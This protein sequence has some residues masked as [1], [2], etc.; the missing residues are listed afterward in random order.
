MKRFPSPI[1]WTAVFLL[2]ITSCQ[3]K[4]TVDTKRVQTYDQ[5]EKLHITQIEPAGWIKE[6]L[7][8][9][10]RGLTGNIEVA[11]Y[12]FNTCLWACEKMEGSTKAWWP[13]E[14]TAYYLD[15]VHRLG[16][17][18]HD[19]ELIG[20]VRE[21]THY[22]LN[23]IDSTGRFGTRLSDRWWRWP[24]A[25]FNRLL[26][27]QYEETG[28][29][30]IL[31]A[32][33]NHYRT[34][35]AGDFQ[36]DLE[37]ANVEQLCWLYNQ[38]ADTTF[39]ATA[40]EAY[41]LFKS[42]RNNR[43]RGGWE[44]QF[45]SDR[46][47]DH[48]GVVYM[49]LAKAP[50]LLY[51]YTGKPSY[52]AEAENALGKMEQHHMLAGGLPSST[53]NFKGITETAG[54]ETCNT[55]VMPYTYGLLLRINGNPNLADQIEKAVF[56]GAM[57]AILK[58]FTA[59]QYFSAPNQVIANSTSNS[60]GYHPARMAYLPGHDVECCTG[61]VNRFMPYYVEQMWMRSKDHGVVAS[62]YGAS[63]VKLAV[64]EGQVV[65]HI[66]QETE[67]PFSETLQF[68]IRTGTEVRFPFYFRIPDWCE[69]P[70][71][72]VNGEEWKERPEKGSFFRLER[73]FH[74][75]DVIQLQLPMEIRKVN[76]C[77]GG[78]SLERGPIVYSLP[79]D[80]E[81]TILEY[82]EKSTDEFPGW[83]L[84][85]AS[86][87]NYTLAEGEIEVIETQIQGYPWEEGAAPVKLKVPVREVK[88]WA[89]TSLHDEHFK[90]HSTRTPGFPEELEL[91]DQI[92]TRYLVPYGTTLLR[93]TVFPDIEKEL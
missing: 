4:R 28:D 6:F 57:G 47:P 3:E 29:Q 19:E 51:Q 55:A 52:L 56:N 92:E 82:Y 80:D 24:Y 58:D 35:T 46:V 90:I 14:Q 42:D 84:R 89:L 8:R 15:G 66:E 69:A 71:I 79:V 50:A 9:Q 81:R 16:L 33:S 30:S 10:K 36:D 44:I 77:K 26:M 48:H 34:F 11:G 65:V 87:W 70:S 72:Q 88:N 5:F 63:E 68:V 21:N 31:E 61:N 41:K 7:Q 83:E 73:T 22:V 1:A 64:G 12:P 2:L 93:M 45:G 91:S 43:N 67:Y 59:H 76:S 54:V 49:E 78:V 62:L 27:L 18:L 75:G 32:L 37:L 74:D 53:E 13:Y 17:L 85:P 20:I 60:F 25:S 38:T 39:L 23:H 40:E 86:A